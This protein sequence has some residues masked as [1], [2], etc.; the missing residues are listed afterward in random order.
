MTRK[1]F[2]AFVLADLARFGKVI[3]DGNIKA[4]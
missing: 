3:K 4:D 1:D 2:E